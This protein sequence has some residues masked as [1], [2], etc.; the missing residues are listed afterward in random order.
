MGLLLAWILLVDAA[1]A[2]NPATAP[3]QVPPAAAPTMR[4]LM[5][6]A[7]EKQRAAIAIQREAVKKQAATA[8]VWLTPWGAAAGLAQPPCDP[9][10]DPSVTPIIEGA[11][12]AHDIQPN[13]IRA[14]IEQESGFRPCAVSPKGAEGLMQLM[15]GT[16]EQLGVSDPFDAGQ[17][18]EAGAKYLKELIDKY[19][20]DLAQA[21]GAYN[22]GPGA[23]DQAGGIP[24][25]PETRDYVDAILKKVGK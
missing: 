12:K 24:E 11:A 17:N 21:L 18:I 23:T 9:I 6:A 13:L 5:K 10:A 7:A 19:K 14:V 15:P 16:A 22:A 1:L 25:I 8:G 20:G 2:Q 4:D 3:A